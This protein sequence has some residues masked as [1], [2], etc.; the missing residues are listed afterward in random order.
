MTDSK[1]KMLM[2]AGIGGMVVGVLLPFMIVIKLLP[3]TLFLNFFSYILQ[4]VGLVLGMI[5]LVNQAVQRKK[6]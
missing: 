6:K 3:S 1:A 5:G 4:I 2:F